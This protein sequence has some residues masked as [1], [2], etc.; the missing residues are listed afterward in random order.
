MQVELH[1]Y[2]TQQ[3]LIK[4]CHSRGIAV[5]GFSPLGALSYL[6]IDMAVPSDSVLIEAAI[7][8]I[9]DQHQKTTAQIVLKWGIQ[10]GTAIIPKTATPARL[11]ENLSIFDFELSEEEMRQIDGLD[12][13]RR[14]NDPGAFCEPAFGTFFPIFD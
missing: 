11:V 12:Q 13:H 3:K 14:F 10:R 2:L 1:P 4:Y 7:K 8:T 9:A 6:S 5:T